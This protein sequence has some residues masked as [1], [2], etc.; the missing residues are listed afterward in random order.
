MIYHIQ[1]LTRVLFYRAE[2]Q[3]WVFLRRLGDI[4]VQS[5]I[6]NVSVSPPMMK[7][8]KQMQCWNRH[9]IV[10]ELLSKAEKQHKR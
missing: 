9:M 6:G 5:F 4:S 2:M 3:S 1:P 8:V 7:V 10:N